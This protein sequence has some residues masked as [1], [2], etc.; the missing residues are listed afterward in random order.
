MSLSSALVV[1]KI[2]F[3]QL[4]ACP[5]SVE[6]TVPMDQQ[7]LPTISAGALFLVPR[8]MRKRLTESWNRSL[9]QGEMLVGWEASCEDIMTDSRECSVPQGVVRIAFHFVET[10]CMGLV[11]VY[12][13]GYVM[14]GSCVGLVPRGVERCVSHF[15]DTVQMGLVPIYVCD[16]YDG[17]PWVPHKDMFEKCGYL[18]S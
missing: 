13:Y 10:A 5:K 4:L 2:H 9:H 15:A 1:S 17:V 8:N 12:V 16:V 18:S 6:M 3:L 7:G 14:M 11:P